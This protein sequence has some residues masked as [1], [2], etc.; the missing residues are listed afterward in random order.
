MDVL[1]ARVVNFIAT[2]SPIVNTTGAGV[3]G[4]GVVG[5][6]VSGG[7]VPGGK[8]SGVIGS[9]GFGFL[10]NRNAPAANASAPPI[11]SK[12]FRFIFY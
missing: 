8:V 3:G 9:T 5:K 10:N 11:I 7:V 12:F 2:R 6:V 1:I 4:V